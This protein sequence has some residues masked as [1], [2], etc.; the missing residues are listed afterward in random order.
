MHDVA[1]KYYASATATMEKFREKAH[2]LMTEAMLE[3]LGAKVEFD[4]EWVRRMR[5][6]RGEAAPDEQKKIENNSEGKTPA[7]ETNAV[8]PEERPALESTQTPVPPKTIAEV[9]N[10]AEWTTRDVDNAGSSY[11]GH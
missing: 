10:A 3:L 8:E 7:Q 9:V 6:F 5:D 2:E 4:A 11:R 1:E